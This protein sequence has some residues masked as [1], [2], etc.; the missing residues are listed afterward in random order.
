MK[1]IGFV[2]LYISEWHANNYPV[3]IDEAAKKL[4]LDYKVTYAWA[5]EYIS[6]VDGKNTDEWCEEFGIKRCETV[7][8]LCQKSD[9]IL[10]LAPSN[11]ESHL[12]LAEKVLPFKK[13]TYIDKTF[14]PDLATAKKIF[15]LGEKYGT[16]FFSTSA[17]R[18][19]AE[20]KEFKGVKNLFL[21]GGGR[22]LNEYI[23]HPV[24][25]AVS[26][27]GGAFDRVKCEPMGQQVYIKAEGKENQLAIMFSPAFGYSLSGE[28][29]DGTV[30]KKDAS[31]GFFQNLMEDILLFFEKGEL[32][33]SGEE[34]L[35]VMRLRDG[36]LAAEENPETWIEL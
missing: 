32:P 11:P 8:E 3:W 29:A 24:E 19:A 12:E 17:L 5:K 27:F 35:E 33:F 9:V 25:M 7:E 36:I 10:L 30:K 28:F 6:P 31:G 21:T 23:I 1:K 14:A 15:S 4:G 18:Y 22:S 26:L 13:P 20:V 34:T 16:P 2:D